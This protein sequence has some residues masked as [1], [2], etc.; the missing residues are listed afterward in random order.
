MSFLTKLKNALAPGGGGLQKAIAS[1]FKK[2]NKNWQALVSDLTDSLIMADVTPSF[3]K[4]V[5]EQLPSNVKTAGEATQQLITII[6][7]MISPYEKKLDDIIA[8][9]DANTPRWS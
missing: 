4:N 7:N 8:P 1:S 6:T 5:A 3:A 9:L 2:S